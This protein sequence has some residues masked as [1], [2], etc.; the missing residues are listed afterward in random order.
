MLCLLQSRRAVASVPFPSS[1][2]VTPF[3]VGLYALPPPPNLMAP[4]L[5]KLVLVFSNRCADSQ[6]PYFFSLVTLPLCPSRLSLLFC[7]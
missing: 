7:S 6:T 3:L 5:V 4:L 2:L 1:T